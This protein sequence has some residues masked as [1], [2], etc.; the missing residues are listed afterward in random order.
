MRGANFGWSG[1][2]DATIGM[3]RLF[4]GPVLG[5]IGTLD[6]SPSTASVGTGAQYW[7][8]DVSSDAAALAYLG[9][10]PAGVAVLPSTGSQTGDMNAAAG[11]WDPAFRAALGAFQQVAGITV[12][13]FIGP[14]SR[15]K[16]K[17]AVDAKNATNPSPPPNAAPG[18]APSP[19]APAAPSSA[20][21]YAAYA[22]GAAA[23][24][25]IGWYALKGRK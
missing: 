12:D 14:V 24:G 6:Y 15:G 3:G 9:F 8:G 18:V 17:I 16:L 25:G 4:T 11:A 22:L 23:V 1:Y 21:K 5:S 20:L 13:G 7:P 2:N 10:L 19:S